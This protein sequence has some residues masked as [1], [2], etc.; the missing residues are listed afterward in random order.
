[1][2]KKISTST[3]RDLPNIDWKTV[4]LNPFKVDR[5]V[6][7]WY[8]F[9]IF[10]FMLPVTIVSFAILGL[11]GLF[12]VFKY[13]KMDV[14]RKDT[15]AKRVSCLLLMCAR[16]KLRVIDHSEG[17]H[18]QLF[19]G[20][21]ICMLEGAIVARAVGHVRFLAASFSKD[22]PLFGSLIRAVE[23]IFV[24]RHIRTNNVALQIKKS[25]LESDMRHVIFP[26]GSYANGK[27]LLEFKS[28]AF[29]AGVPI[30]PVLF[31]YGQYVPYWNRRESSF[32]AQMYRFLSRFYTKAT[33]EILPAY[34]PNEQE[35]ESPKI[36]AEN[37]RRYMSYHLKCGLSG[38]SVFDS[39]NYKMDL[40]QAKH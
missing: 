2:R 11:Y 12:V 3:I 28:G 20:N 37:V 17:K 10:I 7:C 6:P 32:G 34:L 23:P 14:M 33:V 35:K 13:P 26:E 29:V 27:A 22:I 5:Q 36:Y 30:T 18:A 8:S 31:S 19:I 16:L 9:P 39:P 40:E 24:E 38:Y 25:I 15:V 4:D 1:M 21:H